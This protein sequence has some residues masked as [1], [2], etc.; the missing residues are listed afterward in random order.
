MTQNAEAS[1][2][3]PSWDLHLLMLDTSTRDGLLGIMFDSGDVLPRQGAAMFVGEIRQNVSPPEQN[4]KIIQTAA[5][6][7]GHALN[8]AH[9][10]ERQVGRANSTSFMNYDW[11][12][13]GGGHRDEFWRNF[14]YAFDDDDELEFL[15]H[16]P[17]SY[18]EVHPS[19]R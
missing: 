3:T 1:L 11:R 8:L 5:H 2:A 19:T 18:P 10:F 9:R 15:R 14:A 6:E 7:L 17:R 4:R 13:L 12:Y 16:A